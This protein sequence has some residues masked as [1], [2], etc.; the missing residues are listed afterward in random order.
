M[1]DG[2]GLEGCK[3]SMEVSVT[4]KDASHSMEAIDKRKRKDELTIGRSWSHWPFLRIC[5][6]S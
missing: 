1:E 3:S 4:Q 2:E 5:L 6:Q